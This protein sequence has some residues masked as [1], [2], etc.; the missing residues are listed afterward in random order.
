MKIIILKIK[1]L[2]HLS[3]VIRG[4]VGELKSVRNYRDH[5][6]PYQMFTVELN[7]PLAFMKEVILPSTCFEVI[8]EIDVAEELKKL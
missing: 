6:G 5:D 2:A 4:K 1:N 8:E 7:E 3:E